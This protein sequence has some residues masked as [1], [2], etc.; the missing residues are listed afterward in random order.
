M[1]D[2]I[3]MEDSTIAINIFVVSKNKKLMR[4]YIKLCSAVTAIV[5]FRSAETNHTLCK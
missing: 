4:S 3:K 2:N 1:T 5:G